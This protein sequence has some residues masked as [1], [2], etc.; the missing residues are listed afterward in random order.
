MRRP[1]RRTPATSSRCRGW[2]S[3]TRGPAATRTA[4]ASTSNSWRCS[5]RTSEAFDELE[6]AIDCGYR[7]AAHLQAD[8][9]LESLHDDPRFDAL[10][11]RLRAL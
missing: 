2:A 9:D 8:E 11:A 5:P 4:C 6:A 10:I 1:S 3:P 7:D